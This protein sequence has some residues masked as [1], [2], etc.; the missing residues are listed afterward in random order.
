[1]K[2][3]LSLISALTMCA[4][5]A[6][7]VASFASEPETEPTTKTVTEASTYDEETD[8]DG[9]SS[10][11]ELSQTVSESYTVVIPA[12]SA[13]LDSPVDLTVSAKDVVINGNQVL[14]IDVS[15][16]NTWKLSDENSGDLAYTLTSMKEETA[17]D[18][19]GNE[20]T[21]LVAGEV[22]VSKGYDKKSLTVLT[23]NAGT[24]SG[25]KYLQAE[26][27]DTPTMAGTYTDTLTFSVAV[28]TQAAD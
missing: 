12:G 25:I 19:D 9:T 6:A 18:E 23:I 24:E 21:A 27:V 13:D 5:M 2:K 14:T 11:F 26:V 3:M 20:T 17:E 16:A 28:N 22:L 8:E 10:D 4:V 7:P 1:M 15:S